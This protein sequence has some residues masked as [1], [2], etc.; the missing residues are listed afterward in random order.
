MAPFVHEIP[1]RYQDTDPQGHVFNSRY[2]EFLDVA[3]MEFF[4]GFGWTYAELVERGFD[5]VLGR[6]SIEFRSPAL[7]EEDVR[8]EII[9]GRIG[10]ASFDLEATMSGDGGRLLAEVA[11]SYVNFDVATRASSPLPDG[12]RRR[13]AAAA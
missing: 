5:P 10:T 13:L 11:A 1:V 9:P 4:R 8:I 7:F 3:T 6:V 12:I 2:M